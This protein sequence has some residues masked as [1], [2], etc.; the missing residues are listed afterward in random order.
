M[1]KSLALKFDDQKILK[2]WIEEVRELKKTARINRYNKT[3]K[4][5]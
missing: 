2:S 1:L 3:I 4:W 5:L